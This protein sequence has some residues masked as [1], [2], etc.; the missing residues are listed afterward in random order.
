M[1]GSRVGVASRWWTVVVASL[2]GGSFVLLSSLTASSNQ[3]EG[4]YDVAGRVR[5][6]GFHFR[7]LEECFMRRINT[8]RARHGLRRLGWD[9]Q[10]G[11]V[12]RK[13]AR[14]MAHRRS[15]SH[16]ARLGNRLTG[17]RALGQNSG[18]G[19]SC[20]QLVATFWGSPAHRTNILGRWRWF[21]VGVI[22]G[23]GGRLY[24]QQVFEF[25]SNPGNIYRFP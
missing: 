12:A 19:K 9:K 16:D 3:K 10:L 18:T 5:R 8:S 1:A 17:W 21:G 15:V 2:L 7:R 20:R 14:A 11:F 24:V 23:R 22:R 6:Y 13:H 25:K 4:A